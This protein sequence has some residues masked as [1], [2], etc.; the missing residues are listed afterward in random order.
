MGNFKKYG[1]NWIEGT[2]SLEIELSMIRRG[3]AWNK[4]Q[5]RSLFDHFKLAMTLLWPEDDHTRWTDLMLHSYCE[6][7]ISIFLGCSDSSKS[8]TMSKI[9]L[10]DYWADP[11]KTLSL[12]STTE[13]RGAELRI[14]GA[15]KDLFNQARARHDYLAGNPLD[16][17]KTIT[18]DSLDEE[19]RDA[20]SL[21][22]GIIVIPCK[23]GGVQSGL[24]PFIGIKAPRLR[25][26]GD[27]LQVM[28]EA[29]LNAYSNW[30]GKPD[31]KGMMA[32]N[33]METDDPLGVASEPADGWDAFVDSGKTQTWRSRFFNSHVVALDGRDSPNNDF[34][35]SPSGSPRYPYYISSKKLNAVIET[36][37]EDSWQWWSQC[38]G[39]PAKGMDIW[40][41]LSKDFCKK[42][43]ASDEVIWKD[44]QI[45]HLY[46][47]DPAYGGGDLCVGRHLELGTDIREK[48]TLFCHP[49]E[50]I[51]IKANT[52]IDPEDQIAEY[53]FN[54]LAK[55]GVEAPNCFYDSFGR[56][57]LGNAFAKLFGSKCPTPVDSGAQAS[58]R[59]VR[60]DLFV[61]E[62]AEK[63][64]KR[65]DEHYKKF[66]TEMYFSI[67]EA[68]DS[69][70]MRGVDSD[71]IREGSARKFTKNKDA[72]LELEPKDDYKERHQG[73]SP[74]RCDNLA[75]G[76]EGARQRGF[77]IEHLGSAVVKKKGPDW[78]EKQATEYQDFLKGRQLQTA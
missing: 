36:H 56:G 70:Q 68:I 34:P 24:A 62:G 22:R 75:I 5:G 19:K 4:S 30:Y 45:L 65:C 26:C 38:V 44:S 9:V 60:F 46:A 78:L 33:F 54:R 57:T 76:V 16:Y 41:V 15:I 20:R 73:R 72:K 10:I 53:V 3:G 1:L 63:R 51:P 21:R 17:L 18:T 29:F 67:R 11:Y 28:S 61:G 59:P 25:H 37:G 12:V 50:I 27:E 42:H 58:A 48:Q 23:T 71:S 52:G 69:D 2:T 64:P 14:W 74:D 7:E 40:R 39:K 66:I 47:L 35:L 49:P 55:I 13:G 43:G 6:N 32:G 8:W 31:F 77:K